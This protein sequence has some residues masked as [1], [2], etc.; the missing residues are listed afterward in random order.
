MHCILSGV[1]HLS[2]VWI[3][4]STCA[5]GNMA[6]DTNWSGTYPSCAQIQLNSYLSID[7]YPHV[8]EKICGTKVLQSPKKKKSSIPLKG[9]AQNSIPSIKAG[10]KIDTVSHQLMIAKM[11]MQATLISAIH[12]CLISSGTEM[13]WVYHDSI[14]P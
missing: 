9:K 4:P 14:V 11:K 5:I 13:K 7:V 2:F 3:K 8:Q 10:W 6:L 1:Q 12:L